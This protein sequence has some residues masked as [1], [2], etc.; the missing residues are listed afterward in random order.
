[1]KKKLLLLLSLCLFAGMKAFAYDACIDDIYY[2]FSGNEA[3]VTY[4][5]MIVDDEG[6]EFIVSDYSG[7]VNIPSSII[8]NGETYT[9]TSIGNL[10]FSCCSDL[11]SVTIPNSVRTIGW[12]SFSGCI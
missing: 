5:N 8:W 11:T 7:S 6:S 3:E 12:L 4:Q 2:N 9:V 10:A 1:M